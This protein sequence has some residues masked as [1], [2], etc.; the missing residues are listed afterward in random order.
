MLSNVSGFTDSFDEPN[1]PAAYIL[2]NPFS[3]PGLINGRNRSHG[4]GSLSS[5]TSSQSS[6]QRDPMSP[7]QSVKPM[8]IRSPTTGSAGLMSPIGTGR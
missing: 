2:G 6:S 5:G 7:V 8:M 1:S 3:T 4:S